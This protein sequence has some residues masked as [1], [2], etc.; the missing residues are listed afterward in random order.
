MATDGVHSSSPAIVNIICNEWLGVFGGILAMLG[1][2]AAPITSGDTALRS[3][4]LIIADFLKMEQ[5][6]I[7]RRLL[8]CIPM[9]AAVIALL[10]WQMVSRKYGVG[11]VG[12]TRLFLFSLYGQ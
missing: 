10:I 6:S 9:F 8:I 1:V 11:L 3:A 2:V 4:R 12:P 7:K 5:H